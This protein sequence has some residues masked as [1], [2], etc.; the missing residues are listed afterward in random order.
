MRR[1]G[2][3]I[4]D[5]EGNV[6]ETINPKE[7]DLSDFNIEEDVLFRDDYGKRDKYAEEVLKFKNRPKQIESKQFV[8]RFRN[9]LNK[10]LQSDIEEAVL[11]PHFLNPVHYRNVH[12]KKRQQHPAAELI[13]EKKLL[14]DVTKKL[15]KK[16]KEVK[17]LEEMLENKEELCLSSGYQKENKW[18]QFL[19]KN[20]G[21]GKSRKQLSEEYHSQ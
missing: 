9:R 7:E 16:D 5:E 12:K 3:N 10:K 20:K 6:L 15:I 19:K 2:I 1:G 8:E 14:E 4:I 21:S 13:R 18:I 17:L 11:E